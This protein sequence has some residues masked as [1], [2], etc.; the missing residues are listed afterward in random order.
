M[1]VTCPGRHR[2]SHLL[3]GLIASAT[4]CLA[5][6][7]FLEKE[8]EPQREAITQS[9]HTV[10]T[11]WEQDSHTRTLF[12]LLILVGFVKLLLRDRL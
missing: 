2:C 4:L 12:Y 8:T 3:P 1:R 7:L 5:W 10:G 9:G 6:V 11:V